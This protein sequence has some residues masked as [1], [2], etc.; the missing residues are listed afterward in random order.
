ML[1]EFETA[2]YIT[3][4]HQAD[5]YLYRYIGWRTFPLLKTSEYKLSV[6]TTILDYS[7]IVTV[8]TIVRNGKEL[9]ASDSGLLCEQHI[10]N[11][12]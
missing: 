4:I 7:T 8:T 9:H 6:Q 2:L 1:R 3:Y 12:S 10:F 11:L 5:V